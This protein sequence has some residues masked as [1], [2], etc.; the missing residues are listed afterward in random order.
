MP[1]M[2]EIWTPMKWLGVRYF[3]DKDRNIYYKKV[4]NH[5]RVQTKVFRVYKFLAALLVIGILAAGGYG[6][7]QYMMN[8]MSDQLI[9]EVSNEMHNPDVQKMLKDPD[10]Q[11]AL[12]E[13]AGST[14]S[15]EV[16]NSIN[17]STSHHPGNKTSENASLSD[18]KNNKQSAISQPVS[19][20]PSSSV[21]TGKPAEKTVQTKDS[22]STGSSSGIH[23]HSKQEATRFV[24]SKF[25]LPEL[26]QMKS[27]Y[28]KGE[29]EEVKSKVYSRLSPAEVKALQEVAAKEANK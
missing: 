26:Y 24:L 19:A 28:Q 7:Y 15:A 4:R 9:K 6:G 12:K 5:S 13:G 1:M 2:K 11:K 16:T 22:H 21:Q 18:E 3:K 27:M 25:S 17:Q 8:K 10:I 20:E 23:F 14:D 29:K